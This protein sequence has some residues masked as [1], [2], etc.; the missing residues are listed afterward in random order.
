MNNIAIKPE[1]FQVFPGKLS[2]ESNDRT[3]DNP[4]LSQGI[5]KR[6]LALLNKSNFC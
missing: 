5:F 3:M 4:H 6:D 1:I 2:P